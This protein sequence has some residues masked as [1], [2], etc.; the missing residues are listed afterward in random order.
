MPL[1]S[2]IQTKDIALIDLSGKG[3]KESLMA[4]LLPGWKRVPEELFDY[5]MDTASGKLRIEFKKQ[6]NE[7][8]FDVGKYHDLSA[9]D[10]NI[11]LLFAIH[12]QGR[13]T[14]LLAA[15]LGCFVDFLCAHPE[16]KKIGWN[17]ELFQTAKNFKDKYPS[18]QF[19]VSAKIL[20]LYRAHPEIFELIYRSPALVSPLPIAPS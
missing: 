18:L 14:H 13:I 1:A 11:W 7:Q 2:Y 19:K 6:R 15:N 16:M 12:S 17:A 5:E 10:R 8:W 4:A 9:D 20:T 3:G